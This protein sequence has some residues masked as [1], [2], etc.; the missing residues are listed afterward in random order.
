MMKRLIRLLSNVYMVYLLFFRER[1]FCSLLTVIQKEICLLRSNPQ[2]SWHTTLF[3]QL[4][5]SP[6]RL[7]LVLQA[8]SLRLLSRE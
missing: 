7:V 4:I 3:G 8:G 2:H 1:T 6:L 5:E